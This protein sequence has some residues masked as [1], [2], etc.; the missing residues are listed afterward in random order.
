[1]ADKIIFYEFLKEIPHPSGASLAFD[2]VSRS[3]GI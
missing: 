1:M 2:T 3:K